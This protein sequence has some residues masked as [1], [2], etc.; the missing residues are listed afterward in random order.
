MKLR[1]T[2]IKNILFVILIFCL[3]NFLYAEEYIPKEGDIVFHTSTSAQSQAIQLATDSPYS[4]MGI[5][6]KNGKSLEVLEAVQPVKFTPVADWFARGK[7]GHYVVKRLIRPLTAEQLQKI[8][9]E[10]IRYIGKPYDK[11]F[12]WSDQRFYCSELVWKIYKN[13]ADITL[14]PLAKLG[15]FKLDSPTVRSKLKERYGEN[16]PLNEPVI[17]PAAIFNS[18]FLEPVAIK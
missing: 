9:K 13:N 1:A 12:E 3:S 2:I 15:S 5:V 10:S 18:S 7:G 16:I 6:L 11:A 4:H 17:S 14:A 8:H